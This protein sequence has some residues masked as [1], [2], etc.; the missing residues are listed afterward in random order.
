[1]SVTF[2]QLK[3]RDPRQVVGYW[4]V[5]QCI[6]KGVSY[7]R[8]TPMAGKHRRLTQQR[9]CRLIAYIQTCDHVGAFGGWLPKMKL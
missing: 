1:M 8:Q 4:W 2:L 9:T 7:L 3:I 6:Q 5:L